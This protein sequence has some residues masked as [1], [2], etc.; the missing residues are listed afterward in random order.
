MSI[1]HDMTD[2]ED[3]E[4][5]RMVEYEYIKYFKENTK[6]KVVN[7]NRIPTSFDMYYG[8]EQIKQKYV[9]FKVKEE[10]WD[11]VIEIF[12]KEGIEVY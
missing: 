9:K 12:K 6:L 7:R 5:L 4:L 2:I 1:L 3:V 11:K 10:D 8:L